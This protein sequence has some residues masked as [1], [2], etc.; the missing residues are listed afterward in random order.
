VTTR[1]Y[2]NLLAARIDQA[3]A[4]ELGECVAGT[5]KGGSKAG[6]THPTGVIDF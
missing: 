3:I 6:K 1:R 4:V 5:Q 2:A